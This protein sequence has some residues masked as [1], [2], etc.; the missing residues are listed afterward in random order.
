MR[1]QTLV[2][3][4]EAKI[5]RAM[6]DL[7]LRMT[8][9]SAGAKHRIAKSTLWNRV[10][11]SRHAQHPKQRTAFTNVE[12]L[13][14][15]ELVLKFADKGVPLNR[16]HLLEAA[17]IV[18]K[19]LPISEQQKLPFKNG[20]PGV[21][22]GRSFLARHRS[23]L[24]YA[25][26][27]AQEEK[28]YRAVNASTL[29]MHFAQLQELERKYN[30]TAE[31]VWNLDET[32]VSPGRDSRGKIRQPVILR[33][34]G[35]N[36]AVQAGFSYKDR[37]TFLPS[38]S[39]AG[40]IGPCMY[41]FKGTRLPFRQI[42]VDGEVHTETLTSY[43][44]RHSMVY[45]REEVASIDGGSFFQF[46]KRFTDHV[47]DLTNG[48]RHVLLT[49]DACRSH[50]TLQTLE[51]FRQHNV[52]VYALPANTSGKTQPCDAVVFGV[53]KQEV[54]SC[55]SKVYGGKRGH[56]IDLYELCSILRQAFHNAFTRPNI[57]SSFVRAGVWPIDATKLMSVPR[58]RD[59]DAQQTLV[60]IE[61][62]EEMLIASRAAAR[63]SIVGDDVVVTHR[64]FV[65]TTRG[66]V[67]TTDA[68]ITAASKKAEEYRRKKAA[69]AEREAQRER[70][71][72]E[73]IARSERARWVV[74][75][76]M[77]GVPVHVLR[78]S[79]RPLSARRA[80]ARHRA[81][82]AKGAREAAAKVANAHDLL[83]LVN[84]H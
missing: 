29:S 31:R 70:V 76:K 4:R 81:E 75:A 53:Y 78:S 61:E 79:V 14:I 11:R 8:Y 10:Q 36:D 72:Q 33:R 34:H 38:I 56:I 69:E 22:W 52:I 19:T 9:R 41:I 77:V 7:Q 43:L 63:R 51:H 74:R 13:R 58:P 12:E 44:P 65:E 55:I 57:V 83:A 26:P 32:G 18:A 54:N 82:V 49:F 50:M 2:K 15:V 73:Q 80:L 20:V 1:G 24:K 68:A 16:L 45:M 25:I 59:A 66:R 40:D 67:L 84:L 60:S 17:S 64:G 39:A 46:A 23:A 37:I 62:M 6:A 3:R 27:D 5:K 28:R 47:S 30:L 35:E 21:R 42:L 71:E 48:G